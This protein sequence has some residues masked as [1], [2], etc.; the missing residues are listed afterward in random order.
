MEM[1]LAVLSLAVTLLVYLGSKRLHRRWSIVWLSPIVVSPLLLIALL[2]GTNLS[3]DNYWR[4]AHF[5]SSLL[6]P[7]TVAFAIPLYKN[8][9]VL[10]RHAVEIVASVL[11][12]SLI[13]IGTTFLYA[14]L[15]RLSPM[16]IW[17][18][19]PRSVTTPIAMDISSRIGGQTSLTAVFVLI[20]GVS[21]VV[22]GP[23]LLRRLP[24]HS[25]ISRGMMLGL[26]AHGAGTSLA[27]TVGELEGTISSIAMVLTAVVTLLLVPVLLPGLGALLP[28]M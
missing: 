23:W 7:A 10:K 6:D 4:G 16:L 25:P 9:H 21:G 22:L 14:V 12:G 20:T 18:L 3:Y 11:A 15:V 28:H 17:S 5:L 27:F 26:S 2:K 13:A 8:R 24:M 19:T 1:W